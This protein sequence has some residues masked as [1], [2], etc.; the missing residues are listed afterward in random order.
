MLHHLGLAGPALQQRIHLAVQPFDD[1]PRLRVLAQ[2]PVEG[3]V[4]DAGQVARGLDALELRLQLVGQRFGQRAGMRHGLAVVRGGTS[5]WPSLALVAQAFV[6]GHQAVDVLQVGGRQRGQR[7][8]QLQRLVEALA[9]VLRAA[10]VGL[11]GVALDVAHPF[12]GLGHVAQQGGVGQAFGRQAV[13]VLQRRGDEFFAPGGGAVAQR[14]VHVKEHGAGELAH[15]V[16]TLFRQGALLG[17]HGR[18]RASAVACHSATPAPPSTASS[19]N[20]A[21][22]VDALL[23]ATKRPSR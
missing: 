5:S 11:H 8:A 19:A 14:R 16:K 13:Q 23:R 17:R 6:H 12:V 2:A 20:A 15:I 21:A 4:V 1:G 7:V 9:C 18:A 3:P 10:Q 22:A